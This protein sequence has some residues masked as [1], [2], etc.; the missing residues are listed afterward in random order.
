[1]DICKTSDGNYH[2]LEI[3]GFSFA[4]LYACDMKTVV[5]AVSA[6]AQSVWEKANT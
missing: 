2:L 4:D 3:G 6:A 1:M 5:S